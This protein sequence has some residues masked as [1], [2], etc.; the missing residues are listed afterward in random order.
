MKAPITIWEHIINQETVQTVNARELHAFLKI[1]SPFNDWIAYRIKEYGFL[2]NKDFVSFIQILVKRQNAHPSME[3]YLT[4]EMVKELA[5]IERNEKGKQARQYFIECERKT[6]QMTPPQI[7]YS[8]PQVMLGVLTYLKNKSERKD[9]IIAKLTPRTE[10]LEHLDRCDDLFDINDAAEKLGM[11]LED[12][13]N[14]LLNHRWIYRRTDKSLVPYYSKINEGLMGYIP[15]TIQTISG[16]EKTVPS[17]K[18]TSKG[19]KCLSMMLQKQIRTQEEINGF[20]NAE[21]AD[22]KRKATTLSSQYI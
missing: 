1:I 19:L 7:D 15:K 2:E 11:R 20:A 14:Y 6:K 16:R 12:L 5:M 9:H 22:F 4:L 13:A 8:N 3:Y 17:A 10:K 18:I 21:I